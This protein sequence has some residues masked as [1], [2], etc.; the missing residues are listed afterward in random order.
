MID[1]KQK[2]I[3]PSAGRQ[4][5]DIHFAVGTTAPVDWPAPIVCVDGEINGETLAYDHH[6]S[7][8]YVNLLAIPEHPVLPATLATSMIDTDAIISGAVLL[9]KAWNETEQLDGVFPTLLDACSWCDH[10]MPTGDFDE[11]TERAG[12]GLHLWLKT[13]GFRRGELHAWSRGQLSMQGSHTH[14]HLDNDFRGDLFREL[15]QA[16]LHAIRLGNLPSDEDWLHRFDGMRKAARRDLVCHGPDVSLVLPREYIDPLALYA[17]IDSRVVI[18]ARPDDS[19]RNRYS[20]GVNPRTGK[21]LDLRAL[22]S[23]LNLDE[24]GWGGRQ[25]VIGSPRQCG[26][27]VPAGKLQAIVIAWINGQQ[28]EGLKV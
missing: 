26:S 8:E 9:L 14:I 15:V 12:L 1:I 11:V 16:M 7:G 27:A 23:L 6:R 17:A 4:P 10:L 5:A 21:G 24:S 28:A 19:G 25:N 13:M 20:I 18:T 3:D 22:T 2:T